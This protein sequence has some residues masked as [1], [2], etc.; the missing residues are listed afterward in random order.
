M[1]FTTRIPMEKYEKLSVNRPCYPSCLETVKMIKKISG[2][3]DSKKDCQLEAYSKA[4]ETLTMY[5]TQDILTQHKKLNPD[6]TAGTC[7]FFIVDHVTCRSETLILLY[8]QC[9]QCK[10]SSN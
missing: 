10:L 8:G 6:E 1:S 4:W 9:W 2:Y 7:H 5:S 3:G